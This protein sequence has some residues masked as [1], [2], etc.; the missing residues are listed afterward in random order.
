MAFLIVT[1]GMPGILLSSPF[2]HSHF[3]SAQLPD[4]AGQHAAIGPLR[5]S[6]LAF[7]QPLGG[8]INGLVQGEAR[9]LH[10]LFR[11]I[12]AVA[13]DQLV[14]RRPVQADP[15]GN[16]GDRRAEQAHLANLPD[17]AIA[18]WHVGHGSGLLFP[19]G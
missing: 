12:Q 6:G 10:P 1:S 19:E 5:L 18:M 14:D 13:L 8:V 7:G 16:L 2:R 9:A 4:Q 17:Q 15:V 11:P 3:Q